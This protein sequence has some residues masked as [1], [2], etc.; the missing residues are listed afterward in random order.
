MSFATV[1][2]L[3]KGHDDQ[4]DDEVNMTRIAYYFSLFPALTT[5]FVQYQVRATGELGLDFILAANRKPGPGQYH[6]Q[7][8]DL[9]ERT[10]YLTPVRP[11]S[12]L[13]ANFKSLARSPRCYLSA[14]K[15]ALKLHDEYPWQVATNLAHA[16]G[17]AV[18]AQHLTARGV[19]HVHIHFAYGAAEVA[20]FL[21]ALSGISYSISIHGSDV[22]LENTLLK[23]KLLRARFIVSNCDFHITRLR[24]LYPQLEHQRFYVVP[25]GLDLQTGPWSKVEPAETDMPLRILHIGRL[26]PVKAQEDLIDACARLRDQGRQFRCLIVGDGPRRLELEDMIKALNLQDCVELIGARFEADIVKLYEWAHVLVLSS[27]SEGTPMVIIEAM[28]KGRPVVVPDITGIPEMVVDGR[29]GYLFPS[30]DVESLAAKLTRFIEAPD[31]IVR[32]GIEGRRRAE[33]LF[34]LTRNAEMLSSIFECELPR[35]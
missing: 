23:E 2:R 19:R 12:Y 4:E 18:L 28:A 15:L 30:G 8:E 34:D 9:R 22:L 17:A 3:P 7:D 24:R 35:N 29:T 20:I 11:L 21:D 32:M 13:T 16:A 26:A 27:R 5:S 6:P 33:D 1:G 31:S 14:L 10:F 25:G